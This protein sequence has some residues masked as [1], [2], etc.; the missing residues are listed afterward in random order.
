M[1]TQFGPACLTSQH[2][3]M[4]VNFNKISSL[5]AAEKPKTVIQYPG[6]NFEDSNKLFF[7]E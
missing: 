2:D 5:F 3:T 6:V 7:S 1:W 4:C